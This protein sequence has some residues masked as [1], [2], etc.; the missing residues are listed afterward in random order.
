M[1]SERALSVDGEN[2]RGKS[3]L[4]RSR[5]GP[6]SGPNMKVGLLSKREKAQNSLWSV[7]KYFFFKMAPFYVFQLKNSLYNFV[8]MFLVP[9]LLLRK[10]NGKSL[11]RSICSSRFVEERKGASRQWSWSEEARPRERPNHR[12]LEYSK[13]TI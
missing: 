4:S 9:F 12:S 6:N 11:L 10:G 1:N 8:K 7:G 3:R 5:N 2:R 13:Q